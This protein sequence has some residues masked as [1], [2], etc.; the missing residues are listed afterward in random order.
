MQMEAYP[1]LIGRGLP[2]TVMSK[3]H[4]WVQVKFDLLFLAAVG[5]GVVEGFSFSK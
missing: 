1:W 3:T 5:S 4:C 2:G